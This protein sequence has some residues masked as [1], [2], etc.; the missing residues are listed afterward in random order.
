MQ[1]SDDF[2]DDH[3]NFYVCHKTVTNSHGTVSGIDIRFFINYAT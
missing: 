2:Y 1:S 3:Y